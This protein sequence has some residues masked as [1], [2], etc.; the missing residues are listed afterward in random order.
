MIATGRHGRR[1]IAFTTVAR[2]DS[3]PVG[4]PMSFSV[5]FLTE[6]LACLKATPLKSATQLIGPSP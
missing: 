3:E 2:P 5:T 4:C 6:P 1:A